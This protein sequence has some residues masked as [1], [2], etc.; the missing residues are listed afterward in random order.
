[1]KIIER[2][3]DRHCYGGGG[4]KTEVKMEHPRNEL[5]EG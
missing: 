2:K 5:D 1:V 3:Q 4:E